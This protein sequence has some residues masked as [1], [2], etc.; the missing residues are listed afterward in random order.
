MKRFI[1]GGAAMILLLCPIIVNAQCYLNDESHCYELWLYSVKKGI[2]LTN[3]LTLCCLLESIANILVTVAIGLA[4]IIIIVSGIMYMT[5]GADQNKVSNAK[6]TLIYGLIGVAIVFLAS[7]LI[8]LLEEVI[9][10]RLV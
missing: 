7:F 4:I 8:E 5:A 10:N 2:S 9:V 3:S 6:K 1:F